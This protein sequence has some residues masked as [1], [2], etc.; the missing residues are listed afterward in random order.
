MTKRQRRSYRD[1]NQYTQLE[2]LVSKRGRKTSAQQFMQSLVKGAY[3]FSKFQ[4]RGYALDYDGGSGVG[5]RFYGLGLE[6]PGANSQLQ[7]LYL[8]NLTTLPQRFNGNYINNTC[9]WRLQ[10]NPSTGAGNS[11]VSWTTVSSLNE[12]GSTISPAYFGCYFSNTNNTTG[13]SF[14][15][16]LM[17]YINLRYTIRGPTNRPTRVV[18]QMIQPMKWFTA[19]P[20]PSGAGTSS[21]LGYN[22]NQNTVWLREATPLGANM[23]QKM[24]TSFRRPWKVLY[25]KVYELQPT[26]TTETDVS[27]HDVHQRHFWKCNRI[28]N[29]Q[30]MGGT[31]NATGQ[32]NDLQTGDNESVGISCE[33]AIGSQVWLLIKAYS[34]NPAAAFDAAIHPSFDLCVEKKISTLGQMSA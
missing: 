12:A 3:N 32:M 29:Y 23:C 22:L 26:S 19:L 33:P 9:M 28:L 1:Q 24:S 17:E 13:Q 5:G 27:G 30:D 7:P 31:S 8:V 10:T 21:T 15:K 16:C 14:P 6:N 2:T 34:P 18:V 4:L 20:T 25:N 11:V